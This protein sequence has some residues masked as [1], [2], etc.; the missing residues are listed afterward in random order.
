MAKKYG[1]G[2]AEL[3]GKRHSVSKFGIVENPN[4]AYDT[5]PMDYE[6][7]MIGEVSPPAPARAPPGPAEWPADEASFCASK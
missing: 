2:W 4:A 6:A 3:Q 1:F 5:M 7:A